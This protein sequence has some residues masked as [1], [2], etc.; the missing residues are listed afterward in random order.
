M[1]P[2][3]RVDRISESAPDDL[4]IA[5]GSFEE[6][7][8]GAARLLGEAYQARLAILVHLRTRSTPVG[9]HRRKEF[10]A[11]L[12]RRLGHVDGRRKPEMLPTDGGDPL[13]LWRELTE[14]LDHRGIE[15]AGARVTVDISCL[16]RVQV[17]FLLRNMMVFGGVE[18]L[19]VLYA[20]PVM[21]HSE[22]SRRS[23]LSSGYGEAVRFPYELAREG[24]TRTSSFGVRRVAF[25]YIGHEG[26]RVLNIWRSLDPDATVVF[27][28]EGGDEQR[29]EI[30]DSRNSLLL[31]RAR[32]SDPS[33][34]LIRLPWKGLS[35]SEPE[36]DRAY[37]RW[38]KEY[39][40]IEIAVVPFGPKPSLIPVARWSC[41]QGGVPITIAYS[42]PRRYHGSYSRG[43]QQVY[44][45]VWSREGAAEGS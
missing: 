26:D 10:T 12:Y 42:S 19:R 33:F 37:Q 45:Y 38:R 16:T 11:E 39:G 14:L 23:E 27:D 36:L 32:L 7:S 30:T 35:T 43:I 5:S 24:G 6:R 29:T 18:R 28:L 17:A 21:Y 1:K 8:L 31:R 44:E 40:P 9:E 13:G 3:F 34:H 15:L 22:M 20:T 25:V 41:I 4:F 2:I